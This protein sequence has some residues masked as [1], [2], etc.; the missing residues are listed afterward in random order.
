MTR[1]TESAGSKALRVATAAAVAAACAA[2]ALATA[3]CSSGGS[4]GIEPVEKRQEQV[5]EQAQAA[6]ALIGERYGTEV[7]YVS[8]TEPP[9]TGSDGSTVAWEIVLREPSTR[10]LLTCWYL[11]DEGLEPM[12]R[13]EDNLA[14]SRAACELEREVSEACA[15]QG[16]E[17][18]C[19]AYAEL[20]GDAEDNMA[21]AERAAIR[22]LGD[23]AARDDFG[24]AAVLAHVSAEDASGDG[25]A[26][27]ICHLSLKYS[28][29]YP[30]KSIVLGL[31]VTDDDALLAELARYCE[32]GGART[33]A[34]HP[35]AS[36][37]DGAAVG[38]AVVR[39]DR[40]QDPA[41]VTE[42][43][44]AALAAAQGV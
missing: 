15:K 36:A 12:D 42:K 3:G 44:A 13:I 9:D 22:G 35:L 32:A 27:A 10:T 17:V 38:T 16:A 30:G 2:G 11:D 8:C 40:A 1:R 37:G 19:T 4:A 18:R 20:D 43:I 34:N 29:L 24:G 28:K 7:Q 5:P 39:L 33:S 31:Q 26:K 6:M 23:L 41:D 14:S 25:L 21:P